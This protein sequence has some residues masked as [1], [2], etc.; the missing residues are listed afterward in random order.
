M[1]K[2]DLANKKIIQVVSRGDWTHKSSTC[3]DAFLRPLCSLI[4]W[5]L[6]ELLFIDYRAASPCMKR[7]SNIPVLCLF[8]LMLNAKALN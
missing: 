6:S 7:K 8:Q 3:Q 5:L 1:N 2:K 4:K